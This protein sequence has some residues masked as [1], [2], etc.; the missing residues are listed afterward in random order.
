MIGIMLM[1]VEV[2][3][4][5][6]KVTYIYK[7]YYKLICHIVSK[8]V[9]NPDDV[10][11][12]VQESMLRIVKNIQYIDLNDVMRSKYFFSTIARNVCNDYLNKNQKDLDNLE[13]YDPDETVDSAE[14]TVVDE[15]AYN[16]IREV[17]NQLDE[18]YRDV[19]ILKYVYEY[20]EKEI[21]DMLGISPKVV[22]QRIFKGKQETRKLVKE[23]IEKRGL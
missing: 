22:S 17:L 13:E 8:R 20:K 9:S 12:L 18:R 10:Q 14:E 23:L 6:E 3:S 7:K 5:K 1:A 2:E 11:D 19:C 15:C 4:D 21:A 16:E